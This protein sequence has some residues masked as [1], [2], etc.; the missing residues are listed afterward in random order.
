MLYVVLAEPLEYMA[1]LF[2]TVDATTGEQIEDSLNLIEW[3]FGA[4]IVFGVLAGFV[5]YAVYAHKKEYE[6]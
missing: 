5:I 3:I 4:T 1:D 2:I 6:S